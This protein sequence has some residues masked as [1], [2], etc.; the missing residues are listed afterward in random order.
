MLPRHFIG[1]KDAA[2]GCNAGTNRADELRISPRLK[3]AARR[4]VGRI[5]GAGLVAL[6]ARQLRAVTIVTS[7]DAYKIFTVWGC[8]S[9]VWLYSLSGSHGRARD[10]TGTY[11]LW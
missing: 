8:D 4:Q 2:A 5:Y 3:I 10:Q 7:R 1:I 9:H 11:I 6:A